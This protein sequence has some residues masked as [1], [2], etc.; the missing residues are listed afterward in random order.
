[1]ARIDKR[2]A[3]GSRPNAQR[4]T[5]PP[6]RRGATSAAVEDTMFFPRLRR[7]TKWMFVALALVF[8]L[9]FVLFGVGAGGNGIGDIFRNKTNGGG[10]PSVKN[11]LE[12]TRERPN[13]PKAWDNLAN[14]YRTDGNTDDAIQ[15]Q[16]RYTTLAP[17]DANGFRTLAGDYFTQAREKAIEA[18]NAQ[19]T[20]QFSGSIPAGTPTR[21]GKALFSNPLS[22]IEP[23]GASS[24]YAAALQAQGAALQNA[25]SAYQKVAALSPRDPNVQAELGT[26]ALQAGDTTV[27]IK[28]FTRY[29]ALAPDSSDAPLIRRQ[30]KQLTQQTSSP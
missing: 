21:N 16:T 22:S 26:N 10:G 1:M 29:L 30:L 5:P 4:V 18:Q 25:I 14:V 11:A 2:R 7:H 9:G 20:A 27:A 6:P 13:D 19:A 17:R 15:A 8:G 12:Q 28:A 24:A 23:A 3:K